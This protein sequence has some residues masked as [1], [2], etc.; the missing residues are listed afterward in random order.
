MCLV[1]VGSSKKKGLNKNIFI[2]RKY[3]SL[4]FFYISSIFCVTKYIFIDN[5]K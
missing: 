1:T 4:H 5:Y 2:E 3:F